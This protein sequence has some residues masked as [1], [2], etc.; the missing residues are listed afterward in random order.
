MTK[1][2]DGR[3]V[4]GGGATR[5]EGPPMCG[6]RR[7]KLEFEIWKKTGASAWPAR[8]LRSARRACGRQ[9]DKLPKMVRT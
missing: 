7:E 3:C 2:G 8:P 1:S 9:R 6:W 4:S 5:R